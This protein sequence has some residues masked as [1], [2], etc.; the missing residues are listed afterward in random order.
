MLVNIFKISYENPCG[1]WFPGGQ[2]TR[3]RCEQL[4]SAVVLQGR[5]CAGDQPGDIVHV[6]KWAYTYT[7]IYIYMYM[8]IYINIYKYIHIHIYIYKHVHIYEH[9]WDIHTRV[10][11]YIC[12][13]M[14]MRHGGLESL[15]KLKY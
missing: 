5:L 1:N 7:Y 13:I 2:L 10:Y 9:K 14:Y 15:A 3:L 11:I 8:Y 12:I 6:D 4:G